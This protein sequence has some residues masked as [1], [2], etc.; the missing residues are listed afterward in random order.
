METNMEG[1]VKNKFNQPLETPDFAT[2]TDKAGRRQLYMQNYVD[3]PVTGKRMLVGLA[4]IDVQRDLMDVN[5]ITTADQE[6][7]PIEYYLELR[8]WEED[9]I[10]VKV[11]YKD[12]LVASKGNPQILTTFKNPGLL[13]PKDG[14]EPMSKANADAS[15]PSPP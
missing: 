10:D 6:A 12:P 15:K 7:N 14:S 13:A 2:K 8:A 9:N 4:Q 1:G 5:F 3:H 11:H